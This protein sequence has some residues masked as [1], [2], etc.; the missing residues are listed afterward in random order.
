MLASSGSCG[1]GRVAVNRDA[2]HMTNAE[3]VHLL[4]RLRWLSLILPM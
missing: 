1:I 2:Q 3:L 4:K